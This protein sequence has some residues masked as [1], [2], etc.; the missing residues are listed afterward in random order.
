MSLK[1]R[2]YE[3]YGSV[4][5]LLFT[6]Y[7]TRFFK[8]FDVHFF[9]CGDYL[10]NLFGVNLRMQKTEK[11]YLRS[12]LLFAVACLVL[13]GCKD[14]DEKEPAPTG[15]VSGE[16]R[17]ADEFGTEL[18]DHSGMSISV[19]QGPIVTLS[20]TA[21][22]YKLS[23][24]PSGDFDLIYEKDGFGTFKKFDIQVVGGANT[25]V[26][27]GIDYLGQK[28]TTVISNLTV[29]LNAPAHTFNIGCTISPAPTASQPRPFRLFF[30]ETNTVNHA[31]YRYAPSNTWLATGSS[32]AILNYD[33]AELYTN[34]FTSGETV[35]LVAYGE[36]KFSN[37]YT[38]PETGKKVYPNV[39]AAAPSNVVS[40]ILP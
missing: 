15:G 40:F 5:R 20:E 6:S 19:T 29:T 37:S 22:T 33:P 3:N 7:E 24:L 30:G 8:H 32:G 11:I 36:S 23:G 27:N 2:F 14:D 25:T 35:Y 38:D 34:G 10:Y 28:S 1:H 26:L 21:G 12:L 18:T 31:G 16:L 13:T 39:N 17:L 4:N 9:V